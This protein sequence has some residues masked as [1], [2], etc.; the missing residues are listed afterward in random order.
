MKRYGSLGKEMP[1]VS[2]L[3]TDTIPTHSITLNDGKVF[4]WANW[5]GIDVPL[6]FHS[7]RIQVVCS[8]ES[9][10][11]HYKQMKR[12]LG[13]DVPYRGRS[14]ISCVVRTL[15]IHVLD[16]KNRAILRHFP[17]WDDIVFANGPRSTRSQQELT[18]ALELWKN[19]K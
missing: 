19:K 4:R 5:R 1:K 17:R 8:H 12:I 16:R 9:Q 13:L 2:H 3:V 11:S 15:S 6:V 7:G 18:A 14:Q 10:T